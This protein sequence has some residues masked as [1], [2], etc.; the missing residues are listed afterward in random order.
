MGKE[1]FN[2]IRKCKSQKISS[3]SWHSG[4]DIGISSKYKFDKKTVQVK[5]EFLL[6]DK[7]NEV[8]QKNFQ[9][10]LSKLKYNDMI[11][12]KVEKIEHNNAEF[13]RT[14][15][16]QMNNHEGQ[17]R[18]LRKCKSQV[19]SYNH[20]TLSLINLNI[21]T[22]V[23]NKSPELKKQNLIVP[24]N[25]KISTKAL[26]VAADAKEK[27]KPVAISNLKL[28]RTI[29]RFSQKFRPPQFVNNK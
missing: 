26:K 15:Q 11:N 16:P 13:M 18:N 22:E 29:P 14:K 20:N 9:N 12:C 21:Q 19:I 3:T 17:P 7:E 5:D 6:E 10:T 28:K 25:N 1:I 24:F 27:D 4:K 23:I 2:E 8:T